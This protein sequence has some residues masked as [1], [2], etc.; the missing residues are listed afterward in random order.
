MFLS[1]RY[2]ARLPGDQSPL[3]LARLDGRSREGKRLRAIKRGLIEEI[4]G[5]PT[6]SQLLLIERT[7]VDLLRLE[8]FDVEMTIGMISD[9]DARVAHA[10]RGSVRLGLR[11]LHQLGKPSG[12]RKLAPERLV[13]ALAGS[14]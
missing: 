3:K 10:L 9:H 4:G 6:P 5:N 7:A 13:S 14:R 1:T 8:L 2:V 12:R 11:D